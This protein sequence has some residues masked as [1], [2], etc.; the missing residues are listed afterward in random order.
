M[1]LLVAFAGL[2]ATGSAFAADV[3]PSPTQASPVYTAPGVPPVDWS[4]FYVGANGAIGF[5]GGG[6]GGGQVGYNWQAG[7]TVLGIESDIGWGNLKPS[8][9]G[10]QQDWLGSTR[11]R[12]GLAVG[13]FLPFVTGGIAYGDVNAMQPAGTG[14][15]KRTGWTAGAGVEYSLSRNWSAKVEYQRL[16]LGTATFMGGANTPPQ[17]VPITNDLV[18]AGLNYHW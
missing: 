9:S 18:R 1:S 12:L 7:N 16:D 10:V 13:R 8:A 3:A 11:A 6:L 2:V 15:T 5:N 14:S 4:G 17:S